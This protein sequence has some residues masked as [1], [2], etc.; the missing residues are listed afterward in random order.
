MA[1][2]RKL[3]FSLVVAALV[4]TG[5]TVYYH[6]FSEFSW[7]DDEGYLMA[8]V[9]AFLRGHLLY[10]Q[11]Y[12]LYGPFYY[13]VEWIFYAVT[14]RAVSH[15]C[16]RLIAM[17]LWPLSAAIFAWSARRVSGSLLVGGF[18][19]LGVA[20]VLLF[21]DWEPGHPEEICLIVLACLLAL[22][23]DTEDRVTV[24]RAALFG[25]L[26][27]AL[28]MTKVNIG[29]YAT[30]AL[31][32]ALLAPKSQSQVK[33]LAFLALGIGSIAVI[34]A[35]MTPLL[36]L[37]WA[38]NYCCVVAI[39]LAAALLA[40]SLVPSGV[41]MNFPAWRA[42]GVAFIIASFLIII[43]FLARGTSIPAF[44][45]ITV[46]QHKD[47]ARH[48]FRPSPFRD[49]S[50]I[51]AVF[52]LGVALAWARISRKK[53]ETQ[54]FV[55]ALHAL[56]AA[57]GFY[58]VYKVVSA[59]VLEPL[60]SAVTMVVGPFSWLLL[61]LPWNIQMT[62]K[63]FSRIVLCFFSVFVTLYAFPVA[64]SQSLFSIVPLILTMAVFLH[65]AA[66]VV[67]SW[68]PQLAIRPLRLTATIAVLVLLIA[69]YGRELRRARSEHAGLVP[70]GLRGAE[71]IRVSRTDADTYQW[72]TSELN[73]RCPSFFSM[74][75]LFSLYFW[76]HQDPPTMLMMN[77]WPAFF[78]ARQQEAII[79]DLK[80]NSTACIVYN[81]ALVEFLRAGQDLSQ[82]PLAKYIQ[83]EFVRTE[84]RNGY[85]FMVRKE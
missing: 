14:R 52:S 17:I 44:L 65:D 37:P 40:V 50:V 85:Y 16:V 73:S 62:G 80:R 24:A 71:R 23:V 19:L 39:S 82:S 11:I 35:I 29:L 76:T 28:A 64:G 22:A 72:L 56:K 41:S 8:T 12:T 77:D 32:L 25:V 18:V 3:K 51:W 43:P 26:L 54:G 48:W 1:H 53:A 74:P 49:R 57:L 33:K 20:R 21:F 70:L 67:S 78:N 2:L 5:L 45:Y 55:V 38:R 81:P 6:I 15:D 27:S 34:V 4:V 42:L 61:V 68:K 10:D 69:V 83:K 13:L 60:G 31:L 30:L 9:Q 36:A 63:Q 7:W 59:P 84:Q 47:F 46:I 66:V 79:G 58:G 75:G